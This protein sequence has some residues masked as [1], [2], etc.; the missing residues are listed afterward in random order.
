LF[1]LFLLLVTKKQVLPLLLIFCY[2]IAYTQNLESIGKDDPLTITGGVSINQILYGISGME[3]RRDPYSFYASGNVSFNLYGWSIP[4]SFAYSNQQSSFQQPFN[5]YSLHPTYKWVTGH[6][7]YTSMSFSPYTLG[8]HLFL[9][10]GV[11]ATPGKFKISAMYGRLQKSVEP[12]SLSGQS[13]AFERYGYGIKVGYADG[14]DQIGVILFRA[15]DDENSI[16]YI[17][18]NEDITPEENLVLSVMGSK[19]LFDRLII[20]AEYAISGITKDTRSQEIDLE[21]NRVFSKVGNVYSPRLSSAY[22]NAFNSGITYQATGFSVGV[23]YERID[24]GYRTLGA[25]FFNNDLVSY[26]VNGAT[27]LFGGRVNVSANVGIQQDN[28]DGDKVSTMERTVGSINVGFAA[29]DKLNLSATYSNFTTFT[30]IRSQ[31]LDINQL[32]PYENLDTLNFTQ[33][34]QSASLNANYILRNTETRGQNLNVNLSV[35]NAA[36]EQGGAEQNS[37]SQF[38]MTN[39]SYS[40]SIVPKSLT[41]SASFNYNENRAFNINSKTL[42]PT[43]SV[44]KSL[45]EKKMRL[46][47][48][49]SWNESFTNGEQI[50]RVV[51]LRGNGGY[52]VKKKHNINLSLVWVNRESQGKTL[53]LLM[54]LPVRWGIV[55]VLVRGRN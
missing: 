30:N 50:N 20:N 45:M 6:F 42:G 41:I 8:G 26:T 3:S 35:Q 49:S 33:I 9:G 43:L 1:N 2:S 5:Q 7:G 39:A 47:L 22:Y 53:R 13:P 28:L 11:D 37:S 48:S 14:N 32:T 36:D 25:Y 29:S 52:T 54:S 16:S 44:N 10:A 19:Q 4:L 23:G 51:N 31:F 24:P 15:K 12:D 46:S 34:S 38:Y 18:E 40:L 55:I 21:E 27:A 17:P